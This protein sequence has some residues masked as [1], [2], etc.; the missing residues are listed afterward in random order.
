MAPSK[1]ALDAI[2]WV[3]SHNPKPAR[4]VSG[5]MVKCASPS[6]AF[7]T[8]EHSRYCFVCTS[9]FTIQQQASFP[10]THTSGSPTEDMARRR[11]LLEDQKKGIEK[12]VTL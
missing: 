10:T 4:Y 2:E 8:L 7:R 6:C 9:K 5:S 11:K 1:E 3:R 12:A